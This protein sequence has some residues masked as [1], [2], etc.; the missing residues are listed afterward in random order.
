MWL[1]NKRWNTVY[2]K[3]TDLV[4]VGGMY[5]CCIKLK[6]SSLPGDDAFEITS[7]LTW[8]QTYHQIVWEGQFLFLVDYFQVE[9]WKERIAFQCEKMPLNSLCPW[10]LEMGELPFVC[11]ELACKWCN[12]S[13]KRSGLQW[14]NSG[15]QKELSPPQD[16][17]N[18]IDNYPPSQPSFFSIKT[19]RK[20]KDIQANRF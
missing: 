14:A 19:H 16:S 17:N 2:R 6:I 18:D 11:F 3:A 20:E 12:L 8:N 9:N 13:L 4:W 15:V 5:S 1:G 10:F 7:C